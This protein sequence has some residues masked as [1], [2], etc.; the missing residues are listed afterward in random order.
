MMHLFGM[1]LPET[2]GDVATPEVAAL[3]GRMAAA[4]ATLER[5]APAAVSADLRRDA[6]RFLDARRRGD[7]RL[8]RGAAARA[9]DEHARALL[10]LTVDAPALPVGTLERLV[11]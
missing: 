3:A 6:R 9:C 1:T 5:G 7:L 4:A 10:R 11:A 8:P 2:M